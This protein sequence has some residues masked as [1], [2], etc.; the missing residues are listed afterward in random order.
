MRPAVNKP[1]TT[2][3]TSRVSNEG[4]VPERSFGK[5]GRDKEVHLLGKYLS[6]NYVPGTVPGA[7]GKAAKTIC[8]HA[9]DSQ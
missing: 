7:G 5:Q 9:A 3:T 8:S 4:R 2:Q 1:T 6:A